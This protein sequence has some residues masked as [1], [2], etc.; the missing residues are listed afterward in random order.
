MSDNYEIIPK[1]DATQEFIET[2]NYFSNPL[3]IVRL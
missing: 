3:N 1:V 2:A